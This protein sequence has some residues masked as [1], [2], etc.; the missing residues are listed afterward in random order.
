MSSSNSGPKEVFLHLL[1][2][3]MLYATIVSFLVLLFQYIN[4]LFPDPLNYVPGADLDAIRSSSA[5]LLIMFPV[6]LLTSW[7]LLKDVREAPEKADLRVRRWLLSFTI[8]L[9]AI[10]II[11]DL[12]TLV[13]NFLNG[14][15]TPRFLLKVLVVLLVAC[16][17]FFYELWSL[18]RR[19]FKGT[20]LP[21]N[22][23]IASLAVVLL[24]VVAGFFIIGSPFYQRKVRFD[25]RRVSDL[26]SIQSEIYSYWSN[27]QA[28]PATVA[29]LKNDVTGFNPPV[30]PATA[31]PYE[32]RV[33]SKLSF[34]LC[35][36]F[37]TKTPET[38]RGTP[39]PVYPYSVDQ[40]WKHEASR[41]CFTRT[42]DPQLL[43]PTKPVPYR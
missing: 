12:V 6:Y 38:V 36:E 15:V 35:A 18:R 10:T 27:K 5:V 9:A 33:V 40:N 28:L 23:G 25:D 20:S 31:K 14:D 39:G 11:I 34:E 32:Y 4:H 29:A 2:I 19:D 41:T 16:A 7:L 24:A 22:A 17:V 30:D 26:Q 37:Q 13:Y 43:Q 21:R 8:F 3:G 42:I 1:S